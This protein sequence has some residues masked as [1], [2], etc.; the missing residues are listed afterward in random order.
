MFEYFLVEGKSSAPFFPPMTEPAQIIVTVRLI[1]SFPFRVFKNIVLRVSIA[2]SIGD[3]KSLA[4]ESAQQFKAFKAHPYDTMK[5]YVK[6][7]GS[8]SQNLII[9]LDD[10]EMLDNEKTL[11][12]YNIGNEDEISFFNY[13]EYINFKSDPQVKW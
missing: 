7:H 2:M 6:Q 13:N 9:N 5:L 10:T 3:L 1:K 4:I 11:M 12:E 8:K